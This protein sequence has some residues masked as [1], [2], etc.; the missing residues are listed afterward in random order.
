MSALHG[1]RVSHNAI[2][3]CYTVPVW[4]KLNGASAV[5][6]RIGRQRRQACRPSE[7]GTLAQAECDV[8]TQGG[9]AYSQWSMEVPIQ[10]QMKAS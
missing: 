4:I 7:D 8:L 9:M 5:L 6:S 1:Y 2:Q 3:R 10:P